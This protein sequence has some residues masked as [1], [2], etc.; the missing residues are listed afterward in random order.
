[1]KMTAQQFSKKKQAEHS[2]TVTYVDAATNKPCKFTCSNA[3]KNSHWMLMKNNSHVKDVV[4]TRG[5]G[6]V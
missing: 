2:W 6:A 1:M 4:F 5:L 3:M